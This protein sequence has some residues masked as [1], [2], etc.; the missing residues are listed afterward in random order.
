MKKPPANVLE[1]PL[2]ERALMALRAAVEKAINERVREGLPVYI[3]RNGR[4]VEMSRKELRA[5]SARGRTK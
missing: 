1:L 4:V 3:W 2:E 5:R